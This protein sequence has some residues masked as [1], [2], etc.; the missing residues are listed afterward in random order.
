MGWMWF[1]LMKQNRHETQC[2][3]IKNKKKKNTRE[4]NEEKMV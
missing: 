2:L 1:D 4:K 3:A